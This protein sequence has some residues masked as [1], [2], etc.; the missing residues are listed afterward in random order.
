MILLDSAKCQEQDADYANRKGF[1]KHKP[2]L[3]LYEAR[4][5]E[6]TVQMFRTVER[7][8]WFSPAEPIWMRYH[9]AGHLLGSNIDRSRNSRS[10]SRRCGFCSPATS[11][12]TTGRSTTIPRRRRP[13]TTSSAKAPTATAIIPRARSSTRWRP[14]CS[15]PSSAA[16]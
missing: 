2:A 13:A 12:A 8:E 6:Q 11:A 7:G 1:S 14:S 5:V 15:G 10:H 9:D 3:P 16:A 4:D